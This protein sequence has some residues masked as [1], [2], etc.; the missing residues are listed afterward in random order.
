MN[1][2]EDVLL[3]ETVIPRTLG[4]VPEL[5]IRVVRISLSA[6]A[7]LMVVSPLFLLSLYCLAELYCLRTIPGP[8]LVRL[9]MKVR[10]EKYEKV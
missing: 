7:A 10:R 9:A 4:A 2:V 8:H 1:V 3:T 5:H 6:D